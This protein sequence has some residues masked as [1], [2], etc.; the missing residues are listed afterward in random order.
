MNVSA[1][2]DL[3]LPTI[4]MLVVAAAAVV[5]VVVVV[6][7]LVSRGKR[8]K[9]IEVVL[10]KRRGELSKQQLA[11]LASKPSTLRQAKQA[12]SNWPTWPANH[13]PCGKPSKR[14]MWS[15]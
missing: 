10:N 2:L 13:Q 5:S 14:P 15:C 9:R 3:E 12:S 6:V 4:I 11:N 1:L 8:G 7:G